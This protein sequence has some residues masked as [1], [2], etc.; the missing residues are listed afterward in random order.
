[1]ASNITSAIMNAL[2][3][4]SDTCDSV[5]GYFSFAYTIRSIIVGYI[6]YMIAYIIS[7]YTKGST[8]IQTTIRDVAP[9][10]HALHDF[11]DVI[12][13]PRQV[14]RSRRVRQG[15]TTRTETYFVTVYDVSNFISPD[16][17]TMNTLRSLET[18][19]TSTRYPVKLHDGKIDRGIVLRP[20]KYWNP[21][22][23]TLD[24]KGTEYKKVIRAHDQTCNT[25]VG[26]E[27]DVYLQEDGSILTNNVGAYTKVIAE[28]V[29]LLAAAQLSNE[30]LKLILLVSNDFYSN[31]KLP[32]IFKSDLGNAGKLYHT[33]WTRAYKADAAGNCFVAVEDLAGAIGVDVVKNVTEKAKDL[34]QMAESVSE[35]KA[36]AYLSS[37]ANASNIKRVD[38]RFST[39]TGYVFKIVFLRILFLCLFYRILYMLLKRHIFTAI[40]KVEEGND[41][42]IGN[43][44]LVALCAVVL[45]VMFRKYVYIAHNANIRKAFKENVLEQLKNNDLV[46]DF[47]KHFHIIDHSRIA[48]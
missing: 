12:V 25:L 35:T 6:V 31:Y 28:L 37:M 27:W 3:K 43:Y 15:N 5:A 4:T 21:C 7:K 45:T 9:D 47:K 24:H 16:G 10:S 36:M 19:P 38:T 8:R 41:R 1:M 23:T 22:N 34:T 46:D 26:K 40:L 42:P 2:G 20:S 18:R 29:R 32:D 17:G 48:L 30:T 33:W 11:P 44:I 39:L 13:T 14:Q